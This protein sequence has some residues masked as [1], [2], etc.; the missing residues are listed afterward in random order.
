MKQTLTQVSTVFC[1]LPRTGIMIIAAI[2]MLMLAGCSPSDPMQEVRDLRAAGRFR[3]ALEPLR[4]LIQ[5]NPE[6]TELLFI[7]GSVLLEA[8]QPGLAQWP[9][10]KSQSDP[11]WFVR[12]SMLIAQV[13]LAGGNFDN[14]AETYAKILELDPDNMDVR[15]KRANAMAKSPLLLQGALEEV[16]R[17]LEIDPSQLSAYKPQI[18]AYLGLNQPDDAERVLEQL[19]VRIEAE[20]TED[21]PIRG[22]HCATMAIFAED[23]G[24]EEVARERW[25]KCAEQ[26]PIH[27]NVVGKGIEFYLKQEEPERAL[28]LGLAALEAQEKEGSGYRLVVANLLRRLDRP[29]EAEA[30]LLEGADLA[31]APITRSA[32]LLALTE[33]YKVVGDL[34]KSADA[35]EEAL[36]IAKTFAG[37]QPDLLFALADLRVQL[38]QADVALALT[39]NMTVAAHRALVRGAVAQ[40]RKEWANAI[41]QYEE[42]TRLWPENPFAPF[43]GAQ[44]ALALGLVERAFDGFLLSVRIDE[45]STDARLQAARILYA[46]KRF[47][48]ALEMLATTRDAPSLESQL[49]G[50]EVTAQMRGAEA[51]LQFANKFSRTFP[52][53]FGVAIALGANALAQ[54]GDGSESW[55][56]VQPFLDLGFPPHNNLPILMAAAE[57]AQGEEQLAVVTALVEPALSASPESALAREIEGLVHERAGDL[58]SAARSYESAIALQEGDMTSLF[59]LAGVVAESD[60]TRALDLLSQGLSF[61][62]GN[63]SLIEAR[64]FLTAA[65]RLLES[66]GIEALLDTALER[67]PM[68]G[69][70]AFQLAKRL[71]EQGGDP[72]AIARHARRAVLFQVGEE[73]VALRERLAAR[74]E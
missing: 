44:A 66:P 53:E 69:E 40:S 1:E 36:A 46:E 61:P 25:A 39:A 35:L 45:L 51:T 27:V 2:A 6:D 29:D 49:L 9:L 42:A 48:T 16:D 3:E 28:A 62:G 58:A 74:D 33:H 37:D 20:Q 47:G 59:R 63:E 22:W 21:D 50:L 12:A 11:K 52:K 60:P 34:A 55:L 26:Y 38:G 72:K 73:A 43:Y 30:V 67:W 10:R 31:D 65:S 56:V 19:G 71:E 14:A 7:Y 24:D 18:L 32:T 54:R 41:Q 57:W 23:N 13:E 17:I 8:G 64:V 5:E 15:I 68:S 4:D 70:I